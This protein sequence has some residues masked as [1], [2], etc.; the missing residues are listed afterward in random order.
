[1]N[2]IEATLIVVTTGQDDDGF[3]IEEEDKIPVFC[4]EKSVRHTE[5]YEA[6]RSGMKPRI[7]F[8][9]RLEDWELSKHQID[10]KTYYAEKVEYDGEIYDVIRS[11]KRNKGFIQITC[12]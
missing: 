6:L 10:G 8:E 7:I 5:F 11:Y 1:M 4:T 2:E 3:P 12:S 9:V